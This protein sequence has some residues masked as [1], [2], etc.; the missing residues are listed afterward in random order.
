M[1]TSWILSTAVVA[2]SVTAAVGAQS[3]KVMD[4]PSNGETMTM[5]FTGCV[6]SVNHGGAFL[7]TEVA[8]VGPA[9][10]HGD[11]DMTHHDD[12]TMK[13][14]AAKPM[15]GG[16]TPTADKDTMDTMPFKSIALT[17]A[18]NLSKHVGQKVSVTGSLSEG[19]MGTMRDD[20]STLT[21]KTLKVIAKTCS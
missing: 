20:L 21:V 4:K 1:K 16:Q 6:K 7:L 15:H 3:P 2:V 13:G 10:M 8:K 19:A 9:P 5:T 11:M 12:G 17:G 14:D 18:I